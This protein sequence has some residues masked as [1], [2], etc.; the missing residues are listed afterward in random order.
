MDFL[1]KTRHCP[2]FIF[3]EN[4]SAVEIALATAAAPTFFEQ[5]KISAQSD[6]IYVDGGVRANCPALVAVTEAV[7]FLAVTLDSIDL[8]SIGTLSEPASFVHEGNSWFGLKPGLVEWAP[9]LVGLMFREQMEASWKIANLLT[10][11]RSVRVD[12]VVQSG[13]YSLD[14]VG[15][16][17]QMAILGRTEA[18]KK[19]V[20]DPVIIRFLKEP[21]ILFAALSARTAGFFTFGRKTLVFLCREAAIDKLAE[22]MQR[23]P[24]VGVVGASGGGKSSVVRAGLVPRLRSDRRTV[25]ET[26]I[27]VPTARQNNL[28]QLES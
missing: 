9:Q 8:L 4:A 19:A 21:L 12:A 24:F 23:Q 2:R 15:Q 22:A 27:L 1:F 17:D 13:I 6:A 25:C 7:H 20:R 26:A 14:E 18:V 5:A 10:G 16:I 28:A 3:D 11:E